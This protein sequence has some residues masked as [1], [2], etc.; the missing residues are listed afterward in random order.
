[1]SHT[2]LSL[3][4]KTY[5]LVQVGVQVCSSWLE[6]KARGRG[7]GADSAVDPPSPWFRLCA[8]NERGTNPSRPPLFVP[9]S[10]FFEPKRR[11]KK[12]KEEAEKGDARPKDGSPSLPSWRAI[13]VE[14][15]GARTIGTLVRGIER[16]EIGTP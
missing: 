16:G 1:M 14:H 13:R 15:T 12:K 7:S 9:S 6:R 4:F 8:W 11:P 10:N 2:P 3:L 5:V